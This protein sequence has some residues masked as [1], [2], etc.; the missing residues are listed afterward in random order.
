MSESEQIVIESN[1]I[2]RGQQL[3]RAALDERRPCQALIDGVE[4]TVMPLSVQ[5]TGY[6][7]VAF[8]DFDVNV[9]PLDE[10]VRC[11]L[12]GLDD[13]RAGKQFH[14]GPYAK[15]RDA[16]DDEYQRGYEWRRG[17]NDAAMGR[18]GK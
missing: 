2:V 11:Y 6:Q 8:G 9:L 15:P 13:Y 18:A 1:R 14:E 12:E 16:P 4:K 3:M 17:W 5:E 10:A 7:L